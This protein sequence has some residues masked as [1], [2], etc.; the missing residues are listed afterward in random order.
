MCYAQ[1]DLELLLDSGFFFLRD[2]VVLIYVNFFYHHLQRIGNPNCHHYYWTSFKKIY[3]GDYF[4]HLKYLFD[5]MLFGNIFH[6]LTV[7]MTKGLLTVHQYSFLFINDEEK[8]ARESIVSGCGKKYICFRK[9][10]MYI[11]LC[12]VHI[13]I[14]IKNTAGNWKRREV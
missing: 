5:C 11:W 10:N 7:K 3:F 13:L 4:S 8:K 9:F 6:F 2:F 1:Q 12:R 14:S